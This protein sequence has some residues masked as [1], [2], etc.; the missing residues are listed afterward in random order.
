MNASSPDSD[1][2]IGV[3]TDIHGNPDA[4][5]AVIDDATLAG[6]RRWLVLG[7]LV[8][9]GPDP[10]AVLRQLERLDITAT[11]SGNTDRYVLTGEGQHPSL[12]EAAADTTL[13]P[14]LVEAVASFAWTK[15]YLTAAGRLAA[16]SDGVQSHRCVL[17]DGTRLLAVHASLLDDDGPG[18]SRGTSDDTIRRVFDGADADLVFGGH[19]HE[20]TDRVVDGVRYVNPGSVSNPLTADKAASYCI[21]H[22]DPDGYDI[23]HRCVPYDHESLVARLRDCG[24]PG[25]GFLVDFFFA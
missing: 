6:V 13:L 22:D 10:V 15:G 21:V 1:L 25:A 8:A 12:E 11:I 5:A 2:T 9:L 3:M 20:R 18:I 17:G 4:L 24:L 14:R 19:T 16:L 23:E 7:D